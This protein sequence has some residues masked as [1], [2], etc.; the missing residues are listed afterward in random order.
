[1]S[2][3]TTEERITKKIEKLFFDY[4][5]LK[6]IQKIAMS[7]PSCVI[8]EGFDLPRIMPWFNNDSNLEKLSKYLPSATITLRNY[9]KKYMINS[10]EACHKMHKIKINRDDVVTAFSGDDHINAIKEK[11]Y[12]LSINDNF[13]YLVI[14]QKFKFDEYLFMH[15]LNLCKIIDTS[16][17]GFLT[18]L[19]DTGTV[20]RGLHFVG[21]K[22]N[23]GKF[24]KG[25]YGITHFASI[26]IATSDDS[27][28]KRI[29][30]EQEESE[31]YQ[32]LSIRLKNKI[33]DFTNNNH[34]NSVYNWT[35][36]RF[37]Q[38]KDCI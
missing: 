19:C 15:N 11:L 22:A 23:L 10:V 9:L 17:N 32:E 3:L 5:A 24:L 38:A 4:E 14:S 31:N 13:S 35:K 12:P 28:I 36:K 26:I 27:L 7:S 29:K 8:P 33:I 18:A 16:T 34:N 20:L 1:L 30:L 21:V 37:Q 2:S 6:I 25:S